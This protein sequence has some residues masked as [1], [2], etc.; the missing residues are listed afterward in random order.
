MTSIGAPTNAAVV[1]VPPVTT[2]VPPASSAMVRSFPGGR[3]LESE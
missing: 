1:I 3:G 2:A